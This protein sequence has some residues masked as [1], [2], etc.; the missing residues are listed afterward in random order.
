MI[1]EN[2]KLKFT[3]IQIVQVGIILGAMLFVIGSA[4][5]LAGVR[6]VNPVHGNAKIKGEDVSYYYYGA[7]IMADAETTLIFKQGKCSISDKK[8]KQYSQCWIH[9]AGGSAGLSFNKQGP[10]SI[11][12]LGVELEGGKSSGAVQWNTSMI[13]GP[14]GALEFKIPKGG[15]V[16]LNFLWEV[17]KGFS[18]NRIKI[19]NL[20]DVSLQK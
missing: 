10:L 4:L 6:I 7:K 12:T 11:K 18:P 9:V 3:R 8:G 15:Y 14:E 17:P 2:Q 20:I 13:D 5:A 19:G 16:V 1:A